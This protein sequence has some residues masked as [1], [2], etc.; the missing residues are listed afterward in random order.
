VAIRAQ[1][2]AD[3]IARRRVEIAT[4]AALR[5]RR[6]PA[7]AWPITAEHDPDC[8]CRRSLETSAT[9]DDLYRPE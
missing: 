3:A 6:P 1:S 8:I 5:R 7:G 9:A 4:A 2:S